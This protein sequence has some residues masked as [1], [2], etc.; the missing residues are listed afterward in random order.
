MN[1]N[2]KGLIALVQTTSSYVPERVASVDAVKDDGRSGTAGA[3]SEAPEVCAD[4]E[5]DAPTPPPLS[6]HGF[7]GAGISTEEEAIAWRGNLV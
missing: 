7:G 3:A 2:L 5:L 6:S 1:L 4:E